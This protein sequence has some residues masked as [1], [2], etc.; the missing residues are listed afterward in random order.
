M[1]HGHDHRSAFIAWG[2]QGG[3]AAKENGNFGRWK[4]IQ[5]K[6]SQKRSDQKIDWFR[7]RS[8]VPQE[9]STDEFTAEGGTLLIEVVPE[10]YL[11]LAPAIYKHQYEQTEI[12]KEHLIMLPD[13]SY[14]K[15]KTTN[16]LFHTSKLTIEPR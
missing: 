6:C 7:R 16:T 5:K 3:E 14:Q 9:E 13:Y 10:T 11:A 2:Y 4:K 15:F 1:T 8:V 12:H